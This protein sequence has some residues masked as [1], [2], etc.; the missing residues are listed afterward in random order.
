M[1]FCHDFHWM[2]EVTWRIYMVMVE[3]PRFRGGLQGAL[4]KN[5]VK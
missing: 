5:G 1:F 4:Y 2:F 3:N